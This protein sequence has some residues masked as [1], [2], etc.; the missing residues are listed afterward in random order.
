[1][2]QWL[3]LFAVLS[4]LMI[5]LAAGA[6]QEKDDVKLSDEVVVTAT[7]TDTNLGQIGGTSATVITAADIEAKQQLTVEEVLKGV[8]G[9]DIVAN[10]GLGTQTSVFTRGADSKNTLVLVDGIMFNDPSSPNR[11]ADLA[12]LTVDNIERIEVV[13]GPLS[14]LY[15]SN[16]TAGVINII[17]KKGRGKPSFYAGGEGGSYGTWKAYGGTSGSVDKFNFSLSASQTETEGFSVA[18]NDN[19]RIA[20]AGNTSED[21]GWENLTLSGKLGFDFTRDFEINAVLRYMES[22]VETDDYSSSAFGGFGFTGDRF[23]GFGTVPNPTGP[24]ENRTENDQFFGKINIQ[25]YFFDRL[26]ESKLSFQVSNY[27]RK[28]FDNDSVKLF[29]NDGQTREAAWQG[30]LNFND[31][32]FLSIGATYFEEELESLSVTEK[33]ADTK[34]VWIQNQLFVGDGLDLVAGLRRDDHSKFGGKTTYRVAPAYTVETMGTTF[35]AS[36]GTGFRSPSLFELFSSFG[37]ETLQAEESEGWD[38]GFEQEFANGTIR[39]GATYFDMVFE[40]RID[41]NSALNRYNQLP[42]DTETNGVEAFVSWSPLNTLD[43]TL[44]Y[45]YGDSE[46]PNGE[47]LVRRPENKV[48]FNTRYR[49]LENAMVNLDLLWVGD[50][51]TFEGSQDVNGNAV[52][53]LDAYTV[54]NFS[55][56]YTLFDF[57]RIYGRVDNVFDEEYEE[58]WSFATPG[59]SAYIGL[60]ATF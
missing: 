26:F 5:P 56:S 15:G 9:I 48:F 54:V 43:F 24:K 58:A 33:D 19:D 30:N 16:A 39:F 21:D 32:N 51:D 40:N 55:A 36:Y 10:G 20:H 28:G 53:T 50:R 7:R 57:L 25:N 37:S 22:E 44:N 59:R 47:R 45:T 14:V 11:G 60:K 1:M 41:F 23:D 3:K 18:N 12:N 34:S 35:K 49:F 27:E 17:T 29:D 38:I 2:N 52:E 6:D 46:D 4:F 8:P 31:M 42:G 13:R